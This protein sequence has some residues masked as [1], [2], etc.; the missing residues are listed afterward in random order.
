MMIKR[1]LVLTMLCALSLLTT[2]ATAQQINGTTVGMETSM[3]MIEIE[4]FDNAA[5][6]AA[7]NFLDYVKNHHYDGLIFHRVIPNFVVQGGGF[8]PGIVPRPTKDP[9]KNEAKGGK[10]N[11][12]GTLAMARSAD[13]NSATS[14][15]YFNLSNNFSLDHKGDSVDD[16]GYTVFGR[17]VKGLEVVE[18]IAQ[19]PTTTVKGMKDVPKKDVLIIKAWVEKD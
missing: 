8:E 11:T 13:I 3:G 14:Q 19:Q 5:P 9:I 17:V 15:F 12:R 18:E 4:L 6:I 7:A 10:P 16:Y 2:H 1:V